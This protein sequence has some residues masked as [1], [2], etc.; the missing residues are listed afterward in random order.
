MDTNEIENAEIAATTHYPSGWPIIEIELTPSGK[1]PAKYGPNVYRF[2][3]SLTLSIILPRRGW[4]LVKNTKNY[5][6]LSPPPGQTSPFKINIAVPTNDE[7]LAIA[8][9]QYKNATSWMGQL[10][11]WPAWYLHE[12]NRNIVRMQRDPQTQEMISTVEN[13][14]PESSLTIGEYGVWKASADAVSGVFV[15]RYQSTVTS[16]KE[17]THI[18]QDAVLLEGNGEVTELTK[19]ERNATAR[20]KCIKHYGATCQV[21]GL[22]YQDKYGDIGVGSIHVHHIT[23]LSEIGISYVVD[24][25]RDLIPVCANCHQVIHRR[26]PPYSIAELKKAVE[27][28]SYKCREL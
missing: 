1:A 4:T 20:A 28:S 8:E 5:A 15:S 23:P 18:M 13:R 6:Y 7:F 3:A 24:P 9:R 12:R 19:Y 16:V 25:I 26:T 10:G 17:S 22:N 14:P 21:C 27:D 2:G 11:E